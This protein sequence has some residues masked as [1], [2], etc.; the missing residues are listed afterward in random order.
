MED[1]MEATN[2]STLPAGISSR[3]EINHSLLL[4]GRNLAVLVLDE[5]AE[6]GEPK[7]S[8]NACDR[9]GEDQCDSLARA[10]GMLRDAPQDVIRGF[11]A[12]FS[13]I[14]GREDNRVPQ[15]CFDSLTAEEMIG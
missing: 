7:C 15:G 6:A 4:A 2:D 14:A 9:D 1:R 10:I 8:I 12:V 5:L 13:E 11:A 3:T